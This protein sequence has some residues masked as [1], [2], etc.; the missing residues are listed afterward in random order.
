[1]GLFAMPNAAR[2]LKSHRRGRIGDQIGSHVILESD[3]EDLARSMTKR[4][5][6]VNLGAIGTLDL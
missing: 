4:K 5:T 2:H 1:V 3:Q 6:A